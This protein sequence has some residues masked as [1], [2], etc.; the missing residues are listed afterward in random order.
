M[1]SEEIRAEA[2]EDIVAGLAASAPNT[3]IRDCLRLYNPTNST[4][5]LK[6]DFNKCQKHT[7]VDT[8]DYLEITGY[9]QY[10][11]PACINRL[12]CRIQNLFPD[13]C[14]VC[15][16]IYCLK[17]GD[18]ALLVCQICGQ[19]S[20]NTCVLTQ[21]KVPEDNWDAITP[22]QIT[23]MCNPTHMPGFHYL[24]G[25][26]MLTTIPA[27]ESG[28]LKKKVAAP[29]EPTT[30]GESQEEGQHRQTDDRAES[31]GVDNVQNP[32]DR[33]PINGNVPSTSNADS[34][35]A[36]D[37]RICPFYRKGTCRHGSS[38]K[39]CPGEHPRPC[40]KLLKHGTKG[41]Y[42]C[43]L[44]R[45]KCASF[46]PKMCPKSITK[47]ECYNDDCKLRHVSGT[48]RHR[49]DAINTKDHPTKE[50][51]SQV[52]KNEITG[53]APNSFLEALSLLKEEMLQAMESKL[54]GFVQQTQGGHHLHHNQAQPVTSH[55]ATWNYPPPW[56][57][58]GMMYRMTPGGMATSP[59]PL[60]Q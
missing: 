48:K 1:W 14:N 18:M 7:L 2:H 58:P 21:L 56:W 60:R 5:Q 22:D 26:C 40:K 35:Q 12:I 15:G 4:K 46:H 52:G 39:D 57:N 27:K 34:P 33:R 55:P 29:T 42:G 3:D 43:T 30:D 44:G 10:T 49:Q 19:G 25:A 16:D 20:H 6:T 59:S 53:S 11:K 36:K 32:E 41:P 54:A 38:G 47:G 31:A 24:C 28:M 17:L 37:K 50:G 45:E 13:K 8:L 23:T 51:R 9:D